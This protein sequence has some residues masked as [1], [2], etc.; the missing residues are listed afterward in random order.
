MILTIEGLDGVTTNM[1]KTRLDSEKFEISPEMIEAGA[2]ILVQFEWGWAD[3]EE[4]AAR[5]YR[6]MASVSG[7]D[8]GSAFE[9][10]R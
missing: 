4:Y 3:P 5:I 7:R 10:S 2:D 8:G 6:A 9:P 1:A